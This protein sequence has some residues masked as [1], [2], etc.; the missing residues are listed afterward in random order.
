M[1]RFPSGK[2]G[3]QR[4]EFFPAPFRS[5]LRAFAALVFPW[6]GD[7]VLLCNICDRGWCIPSGRVEPF[8]TSWE[9]VHREAAEEAGAVLENL[10]YLGAYRIS[11]RQEVRWADL[12][13][14]EVAE[15]N[16]IQMK[17]ESLGRRFVLMNDL[18]EVYHS[19]NPLIEALFRHSLDCVQRRQAHPAC[20]ESK[21][22]TCEDAG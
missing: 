20:C 11:E 3:R 12:F 21:M 15:L 5:P 13:A 2:Y 1:K 18:P 19:W 8:E 17:E 10:Q 4:L 16:E 7:E 22:V 9:A 14:A 6:R